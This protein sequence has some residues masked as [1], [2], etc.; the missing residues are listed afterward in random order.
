MLP[1][2]TSLVTLFLY[3]YL[4]IICDYT[5]SILNIC[6]NKTNNL[7]FFKIFVKVQIYFRTYKLK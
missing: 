2:N 7:V 4:Y 5:L 3:K 1:L 6:V